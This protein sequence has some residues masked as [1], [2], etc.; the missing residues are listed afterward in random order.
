MPSSSSGESDRSSGARPLVC[1]GHSQVRSV[2]EAAR[3]RGVP[4]VALDFW[5]VTPALVEENGRL[6]YCDEIRRHFTGGPVFSMIGG[7]AHHKLGLMAH[8]RRFDFVLPSLPSLPLDDRA[9]IVPFD[10][11]RAAILAVLQDFLPRMRLLKE[12]NPG[13]VYHLEP[14]PVFADEARLQRDARRMPIARGEV[15]PRALRFKLWRAHSDLVAE[16]CRDAGITFIP[17]PPASVDADG[18]LRPEC[19]RDPMHV[20]SHYGGLVLDQMAA[21]A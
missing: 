5:R 21:V 14:P 8:P 16:F 3:E 18:F 12:M 13:P 10:Q 20:S 11:V 9:E 2:A 6:R 7:N 1:L 19:Y 15:S 4:L 17:H